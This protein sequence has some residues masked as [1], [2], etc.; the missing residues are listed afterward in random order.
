[1]YLPKVD[2][3][4]SKSLDK[5]TKI[6]SRKINETQISTIELFSKNMK[7]S[8]NT[9]MKSFS[10]QQDIETQPSPSFTNSKQKNLKIVIESFPK[11]I[12]PTCFNDQ[13][14]E[15]VYIQGLMEEYNKRSGLT[16]LLCF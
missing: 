16:C 2:T 9:M 4:S 5:T 12:N 10:N 8:T 1:M 14:D 6:N 15:T 3:L 11:G 13:D 7:A